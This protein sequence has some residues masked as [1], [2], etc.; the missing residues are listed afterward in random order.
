MNN[1][2]ICK[3]CGKEKLFSEFYIRSKINGVNKYR[4]ECKI[5][6]GIRANNYV[7]NNIEKVKI[8]KRNYFKKKYAINKEII[9][10]KYRNRYHN[11]IEEE[12]IRRKK[13]S[14]INKEKIKTKRARR[15]AIKRKNDPIFKLK[16]NISRSIRRLL[17]KNMSSKMG[18]SF[19]KYVSYTIIELKQYLSSIFEPWMNWSNWGRYDPKTWNDNDQSTWVWQLDHIIPQSKLPYSSMEDDNFKKCWALNNLRPLSAKQNFFD[20]IDLLRKK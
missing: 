18:K 15:L 9:L 13:Y 7:K 11:H 1:F 3:I 17:K 20:G 6:C 19:I 10:Q 16:E 14:Q 4:T 12:R 5:C 8:N 2:K